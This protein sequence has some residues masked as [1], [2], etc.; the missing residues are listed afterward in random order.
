MLFRSVPMY[1]KFFKDLLTKKI[2]LEEVEVVTM[3]KECSALILNDLPP[4]LDD[5]GSFCIPC[6]IGDRVFQCPM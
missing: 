2:N 5:P 3:T 1:A 4:K 6:L